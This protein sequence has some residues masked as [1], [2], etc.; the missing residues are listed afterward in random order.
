MVGYFGLIYEKDNKLHSYVTWTDSMFSLGEEFKHELKLPL[1]NI[2]HSEG[3]GEPKF[4]LYEPVMVDKKS[5]VYNIQRHF[6]KNGTIGC[7]LKNKQYVIDYD[8]EPDPKFKDSIGKA[9]INLLD[10]GM[11]IKLEEINLESLD[12][13]HL[14]DRLSA[15]LI[16][17]YMT[18]E[19]DSTV[20]VING[21]NQ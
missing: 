2:T 5:G 8:K 10:N 14:I 19:I 20:S 1:E 3:F 12:D 4:Y 13:G 11:L 21:E 18:M 9:I 7:D 16:K 15:E 17:I 6:F